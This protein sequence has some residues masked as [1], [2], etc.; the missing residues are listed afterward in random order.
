MKTCVE[1]ADLGYLAG[2]GGNVALRA[3]DEHI[4]VTPSATDYY[5][6]EAADICVLRVVD[7]QQVDGER[8]AS[9]E[10]EMHATVLRARPDCRASVHTHQPIAS[11][12]TL[13]GAPLDVPN[14]E[15]QA[16]LGT[17]VP[18]IGYAPSGTRRLA[19]KVAGAMTRTTHAC[20]MRNHGALCVGRDP[21]EAIARVG[22]L[23]SA[24]AGYFLER[25]GPH[26]PGPARDAVLGALHAGR[27]GARPGAE[28]R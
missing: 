15:Y 14:E 4:A 19:R 24:C 21:T 5:A 1:L 7:M 9:V 20:L 27:P 18:C 10:S 2:T 12:Y 28:P 16:W 3:D 23:E 11:A 17:R 6:I 25:L 8:D 13:L 22:A 26:L